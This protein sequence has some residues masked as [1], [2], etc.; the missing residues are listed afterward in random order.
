MMYLLDEDQDWKKL[1]C[2]IGIVLC[3]ILFVVNIPFAI[4]N[5][6]YVGKGQFQLI[7]SEPSLKRYD[8]K[9]R[10]KRL[11]TVPFWY[12]LFGMY[13]K[14]TLAIVGFSWFILYLIFLYRF[15]STSD[16]NWLFLSRL[17]IILGLLCLILDFLIA[18][19]FWEAGIPIENLPKP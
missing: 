4:K 8:W 12:F 9:I 15:Y 3:I 11:V 19:K 17:L 13:G 7:M 18:T 6:T 2:L 1:A 5:T 16:E 10:P 14:G